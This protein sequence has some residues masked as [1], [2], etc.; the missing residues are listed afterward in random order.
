VIGRFTDFAPEGTES[1]VGLALQDEE[2]R[3]LFFLGGTRHLSFCPPGELFYGGIVDAIRETRFPSVLRLLEGATSS[4]FCS[5]NCLTRLENASKNNSVR[6]WNHSKYPLQFA[7][8][9]MS[10]SVTSST[11]QSLRSGSSRQSNSAPISCSMASFCCCN[12]WK[13]PFAYSPSR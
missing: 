8:D 2:G 12:S 10:P 11:R 5:C 13:A 3:F 9:L 1:G 4:Y 7:F 6:L